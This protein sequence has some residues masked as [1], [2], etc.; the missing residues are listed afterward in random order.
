MMNCE[1]CGK[2]VA[3][4]AAFCPYCGTRINRESKI[5]PKVNFCIS[6]GRKLPQDAKFCSGCGKPINMNSFIENPKRKIEQTLQTNQTPPGN[7]G[8]QGMIKL[9][10]EKDKMAAYLDDNGFVKQWLFKIC[11]A[12]VIMGMF[13]PILDYG[14][15]AIGFI[16]I[17]KMTDLEAGDEVAVVLFFF[18]L[19]QGS[20]VVTLMFAKEPIVIRNA[21]LGGTGFL[22][23]FRILPNLLIDLSQENEMS[24]G[25][26]IGFQYGSGWIIMF[27][28][29]VVAAVVSVLLVDR[30]K[31]VK[32]GG[33][34]A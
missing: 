4:D 2:T 31:K 8:Q 13:F 25:Y 32:R 16:D 3:D 14:F 20:L 7:Q 18:L 10:G 30:E 29:F 1:K 27:I 22:L 19:I 21:S 26:A 24:W 15:F 11:G 33:K 23:L 9:Q 12:I 5:A 34:I 6:C 17:F 28:P